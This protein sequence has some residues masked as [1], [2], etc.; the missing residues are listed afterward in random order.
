M[1]Y[2]FGG[3][4]FTP[5]M[6]S[7]EAEIGSN[8]GLVTSGDLQDGA[9][10]SDAGYDSSSSGSPFTDARDQ[11]FFGQRQDR[12]IIYKPWGSRNPNRMI[13]SL[14]GNPCWLQSIESESTAGQRCIAGLVATLPGAESFFLSLIP[15]SL[16]VGNPP[17]YHSP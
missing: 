14:R 7:F 1:T 17:K 8:Q 13:R 2:D 10:I 15:R 6:D 4:P 3:M 12:S 11:E 5:E 16:A 9:I